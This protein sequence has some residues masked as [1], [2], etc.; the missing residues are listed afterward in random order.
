MRSQDALKSQVIGLRVA[1]IVFGLMAAAQVVRLLIRP[2]VLV[3]GHH[4]PL[5]PSVL[6]VVVLGGLCIWL[7]GLS[8]RW[9]HTTSTHS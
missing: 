1:A 4:M 5:W 3:N 6:A 2:E 8:G 7:L 9:M